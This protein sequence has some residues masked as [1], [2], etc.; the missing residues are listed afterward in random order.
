M[1][2][3]HLKQRSRFRRKW[4]DWLRRLVRPSDPIVDLFHSELLP[5]RVGRMKDCRARFAILRDRDRSPPHDFSVL[6]PFDDSG[7]IVDPP[8]TFCIVVG[9]SFHSVGFA[10]KFSNPYAAVNGFAV[11]VRTLRGRFNFVPCSE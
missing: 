6:E 3:S 8:V 4:L 7:A 10:V 5:L 2:P 11:F 9:I 1:P